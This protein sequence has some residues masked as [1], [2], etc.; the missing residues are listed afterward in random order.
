MTYFEDTGALI[1]AP[2]ELVWEYL[3][4]EFHG[5]AHARHARNF[6]VRETIGETALVYAER[7]QDGAWQPF[8]SKSTDYPPLCVCNEEIEGEFAGTKFVVVYRPQ[9][10]VTQVD[11]YGDLRSG[12]PP[13]EARRRFLGLLQSAYEDDVEGIAALR[14]GRAARPK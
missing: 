12:H 6:E 10:K 11:V 4:S 13:P 14:R 5:P 7:F 1:D 3:S 9:G 8:V 2:I